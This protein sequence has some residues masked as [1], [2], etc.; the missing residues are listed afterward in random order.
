VLVLGK[1]FHPGLLFVSKAVYYMSEVGSISPLQLGID[2]L[3]EVNIKVIIV[4]FTV[5]ETK[6]LNKLGCLSLAKP[7]QLS[8]L[9]GTKAGAYPSEECP[10]S[11]LH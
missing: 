4:F 2:K 10:I 7:F 3:Y 8:L 11:P 5:I 9:F 1:P 6:G